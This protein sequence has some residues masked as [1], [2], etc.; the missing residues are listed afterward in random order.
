MRGLWGVVLGFLGLVLAQDSAARRLRIGLVLSGGGSRGSAHIGVL[1]ALEEAGIPIDYITGTSMGAMAGAFY[2]AGYSPAEMALL[3]LRENTRWLGPGLFYKEY[4]YYTP[5]RSHDITTWEIPLEFFTRGDAP[6][7]EQVVS[8]FEVNLGLTERLASVNLA[9]G[10]N[11]D[12]LLVPYRAIG[13]DLFRRQPIIF[14]RGSLPLAVRVSISVPLF[15]SPLTTPEYTNLVD[16]GVYDN[17]PVG[18]MQKEF[19]PDFIIGVHVG[20]PPM[21]LEEFRQKG[22][23]WQLFSHLS[24]QLSWQKLPR[25]SFFIQ[26][27]LGDMDPTDFSFSSLSFAIQRGYEATMACIEELKEAIG[28]PVR[29]D[30]AALLRKRAELRR[31]W[32][33]P[34]PISRIGFYPAKPS[35]AFFYRRVLGLRP[36]D[37]LT[38][39]R[40]RR[41]LFAL[42]QSASFYSI[43]P[44]IVPDSAAPGKSLLTLLVRP[45]GN[46]F[47]RVGLGV[48]SPSGYVV[49]IEG[50]LEKIWWAGWEAQFFLTQGS[51]AQS[52]ELR[53]R[54]RFPLP[55][56]LRLVGE[57]Q[58]HRFV[59]QALGTSWLALPRPAEVFTTVNQFSV[60][61]QFLLRR[62]ETELGLAQQRLTEARGP[63]AE[64]TLTLKATSSYLR[65][66]IDTEDDRQ[67]PQRGMRLYGAVYLNSGI[68]KPRRPSAPYTQ[69]LHYWPQAVFR[70]RQS[71]SLWQGFSLGLRVEGGL[72]LQRSYA[73]TVATYL[74]S[75]AFYPFPESPTLFLPEFYQRGFVAG[76]G[77]LTVGLW[78]KLAFRAEAY[79]LQPVL[80]LNPNPSPSP[81][82]EVFLPP[83]QGPLPPLY[84]YGMVGLFYQTFI[85]PIGLF[86]SYYD[87]QP[88]PFRLFIHLGYTR[89]TERPWQ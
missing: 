62:L 18:P 88:Q 57:A 17:F 33:Q 13:A 61:T 63:L 29:L 64:P 47:L 42:R 53:G 46:T 32:N 35:E 73:D 3:L 44:E 37:T 85:G 79:L 12:S 87:R 11:F 30:S 5:A 76:G 65:L 59:Y 20:T 84:R 49:Q 1:R 25:R 81:T 71:A 38:T 74:A 78:R 14:R 67:Y 82:S 21:S 27:D 51:F 23:Y 16:G 41:R 45:R 9:R 40:L 6:L 60:A 39:T 48:F 7:P 75:P 2:S 26:P 22:Y 77:H 24:D 55:I 15:F 50:Q 56:L 83:L 10:A 80:R 52:L 68:E 4:R 43:F 36:N 34:I 31:W 86:L 70:Y 28:A 8:D 69:A 72:S 19:N 54:M 58:L 66:L 89:F